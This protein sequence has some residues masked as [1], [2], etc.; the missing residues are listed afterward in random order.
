MSSGATR[1]SLSCVAVG[2]K[3]HSAASTGRQSWWASL[4]DRTSRMSAI[5]SPVNCCSAGRGNTSYARCGSELLRQHEGRARRRTGPA[6]C[7]SP[8]AGLAAAPTAQ[9]SGR[10]VRAPCFQA[11]VG[12]TRSS[13]RSRSAVSLSRAKRSL[14]SDRT[15]PASR[16]QRGRRPRRH[17]RRRDRRP[18]APAFS[19]MRARANRCTATDP[20]TRL[21]RKQDAT[22]RAVGPSYARIGRLSR[23]PRRR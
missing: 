3:R 1:W 6:P 11:T 14:R 22:H 21:F 5:A 8:P 4:S 13:T 7:K 23:R 9:R 15:G 16:H 17:V 19:R 10:S 18:D 20:R 2:G 12:T